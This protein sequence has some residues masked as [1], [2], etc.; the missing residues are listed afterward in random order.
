MCALNNCI[1]RFKY[2]QYVVKSYVLLWETKTLKI[3][4]FPV[5]TGVS[6]TYSH[7]QSLCFSSIHTHRQTKATLFFGEIFKNTLAGTHFYKKLLVPT[8]LQ[9]FKPWIALQVFLKFFEHLENFA[10]ENSVNSS[11]CRCSEF[12]F[13]ST[14]ACH[15][16]TNNYSSG[17]CSYFFDTLQNQNAM[18]LFLTNWMLKRL[19]TIIG[20]IYGRRHSPG[21]CNSPKGILQMKFAESNAPGGNSPDTTKTIWYL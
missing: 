8:S 4:I 10:F 21:E 7:V 13:P 20:M 11:Y 2:V 5:W 3:D 16:F 19:F 15:L 18:F 6:H 14:V 17:N 12:W 1:E 9:L